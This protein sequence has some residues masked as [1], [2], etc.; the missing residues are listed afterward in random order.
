MTDLT[1]GYFYTVL[2]GAGGRETEWQSGMCWIIQVLYIGYELYGD[3]G[4]I[5]VV[6]VYNVRMAHCEF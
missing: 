1:T 4:G 5:Y 3:V 6:Y 2:V